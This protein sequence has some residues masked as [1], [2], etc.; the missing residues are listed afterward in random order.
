[1][2]KL[3]VCIYAC[4]TIPKYQEQI[5]NIKQTC[6]KTAS[7]LF[8][9]EVKFLYFLGEEVVL[10]NDSSYIHLKG[11]K[12]DYLSASYKQYHGLKYIYENYDAEFIIAIGTD[13]Y[14]NIPKL[15]KLLSNYDCKKPLY[16][17]G[18]G[19]TRHINDKKIYF[20]SGNGGFIISKEFLKQIYPY[21]KDTNNFMDKWFDICK[22]YQE[23]I[24]ACDVSIAYLANELNADSINI[25]GFYNCN[26]FGHPCCYNKHQA[27]D[28]Y[29]CGYMEKNECYQFYNLLKENNYFLNH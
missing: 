28:V 22:N 29:C 13:S 24:S 2:Y 23:L 18:H 3:I 14:I 27:K 5:F 7:E 11:V 17:G 12:N 19:D 1:M 9:N 6:E 20:H 25:E 26:Y 8:P 4:D 16:I 15:L 21:I 10:E